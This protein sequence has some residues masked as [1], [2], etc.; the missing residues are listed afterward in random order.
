M[1]LRSVPS[2]SIVKVP[3]SRGVSE[4]QPG[5]PVP[6]EPP[7]PVVVAAPVVLP[8]VAPPDAALVSVMP[9]LAEFAELLAV[10]TLTEL[11]PK[12][13]GPPPDPIPTLADPVV[14]D[15]PIVLPPLVGPAA[16]V[17]VVVPLVVAMVPP[18]IAAPSLV[19]SSTESAPFPQPRH[20]GQR[21]NATASSV[22]IL[23]SPALVSAN[24][25][26]V[27]R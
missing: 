9:P 1:Y 23:G 20:R 24:T 2:T 5:L 26:A 3:L 18:S 17:P 13:D 6:V 11:D 25:D 15:P 12:L 10:V 14:V 4:P 21:L 7:P 8:L 22:L 27:A 16:V 19:V